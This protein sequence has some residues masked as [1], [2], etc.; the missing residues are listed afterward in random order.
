MRRGILATPDDLRQ[1]GKLI[2]LPPYDAI[3]E[4]LNRRCA[5]ILETN[6]VT[7]AQWRLLAQQGASDPGLVAARTTQGRILDLLVA[8]YID[9][10]DAYLSRAKEEFRNLIS[11]TTWVNPAH[12]PVNGTGLPADLCTAEASTAVV[13]A[14]D[15]LWENLEQA[16]W[17][18]VSEPH[19]SCPPA[20]RGNVLSLGG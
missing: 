19:G 11:W 14:L 6:P 16:S 4:T 15:W 9:K 2:S 7:E 17:L 20:Y 12:S 1:L 10:N 5:L 3:Y 18:A 8:Y 13:L